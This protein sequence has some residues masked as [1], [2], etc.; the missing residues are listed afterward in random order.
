M[1]DQGRFTQ[2][3]QW[4]H[5]NDVICDQEGPKGRRYYVCT[6]MNENRS[7]THMARAGSVRGDGVDVKDTAGGVRIGP[8]PDDDNVHCSLF[9][10][11]G[12]VVEPEVLE[13]W[14]P[15]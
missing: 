4:S 15:E 6:I 14:K 7:S 5:V 13:C 10:D 11:K 2:R 12:L 3:R 9:E 1:A 8:F